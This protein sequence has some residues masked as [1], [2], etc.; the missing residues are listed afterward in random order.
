MMIFLRCGVQAQGPVKSM[1]LAIVVSCCCWTGH[2]RPL[3]DLIDV[4]G[5]QAV[6]FPVDVGGGL[7]RWGLD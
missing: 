5:D 3:L 7:G 6:G 4:V 1:S 2:S